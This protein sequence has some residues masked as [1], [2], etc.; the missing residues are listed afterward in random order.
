M[1]NSESFLTLKVGNLSPGGAFVAELTN[2]PEDM[3]GMKA[4][5]RYAAPGEI[6]RA[7]FSAKKKKYLEVKLEEILESSSDRVKAPCPLFSHCGGCDLQHLTI[8]SQRAFKKKMIE[9]FLLRQ[10]KLTP[11]EGLK[12]INA[13]LP[14][15]AYRRR[16]T[17]HINASGEIGYFK[18]NSHQIIQTSSCPIATERINQAISVL[19]QI[20]FPKPGKI[21]SI[22]IEEAESTLC[23]AFRMKEAV[24]PFQDH[25]IASLE[26]MGFGLQVEHNKEIL[27]RSA[28]LPPLVALAH[29]S[30]VNEAANK[31][32][33]SYVCSLIT[34]KKVCD[35]Y[36]GSG[37]FS[38]PLAKQ[39]CEVQAVELD[40]LL[41]SVGKRAAKKENLAQLI[42]YH[43][44][45][46]EDYAP[47]LPSGHS[48]V[49]DPPR[50]GA[51][52]VVKFFRPERSP[53]LIYISCSLPDLARDLT[54]LTKSGYKLCHTTFIDMFPQTHYVE[55]VTLLEAA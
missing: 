21:E 37:N 12:C 16:I 40:P 19:Y 33:L 42:H 53:Q 31:A 8:K 52:D 45:R 1:K 9:D 35:L 38:I 11:I 51:R 41:V 29:F 46:C 10:A 4:F 17:L 39:G 23:F 48:I 2:G 50:N 18:P 24:L 28:K 44:E 20:M 55:T 36:A 27:Y 15:L 47:D 22:S 26:E 14:D 49:L 43:Q 13:A 54:I 34:S 5:V 3:L 30:Q 32:M 6:V 25:S 7:S